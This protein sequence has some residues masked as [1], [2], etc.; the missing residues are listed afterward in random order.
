MGHVPIGRA[1]A[2]FC[3]TIVACAAFAVLPASAQQLRDFKGT[4]DPPGMKRFQGSTIHGQIRSNFAEYEL[5]IGAHDWSKPGGMRPSQPLEGRVIRTLYVAPKGATPLEVS[6][7][8]ED[9][10]KA[11]GFE[12]LF[13]CRNSRSGT[14]ECGQ[15]LVGTKLLPNNTF[16]K[17]GD[18][19]EFAGNVAQDL[20]YFAARTTRPEGDLWISLAAWE[21]SDA[22]LNKPF[23][24]QTIAL[25]DVVQTKA[26]DRQMVFVD[27][28]RMKSTLDSSG[29][30][31]LYGVLFDTNSA[32][33]KPESDKTLAEIA[34][35]LTQNPGMKLA[36]VGHTDNVAAADYNLRL[37]LQR[38]QAVV[39][40]LVQRYA[41]NAP[42][43]RADGKGLTQPVASNDTEAG[44]A[45]NRRVELIKE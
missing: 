33:I 11:G 16:Q 34:R 40:A 17:Q 43:L 10:L 36:V 23:F 14:M 29:R 8:Y 2:T 20:H 13:R 12:T 18:R 26:M 1:C 32:V 5:V 22:Q 21:A 25:L 42:R 15:K 19:A 38:A 31:S 4:Q 28:D 35:L 30:I 24:G 44:R 7:N 27:A 3:V 45:Q 37:S 6:R 9:E 39:A 41:I